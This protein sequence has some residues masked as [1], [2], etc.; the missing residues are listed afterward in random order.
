MDMELPTF[1][2]HPDPVGTGSVVAAQVVCESCGKARGYVYLGPVYGYE[3]LECVCPWCIADGS[4]HEK[5]GVSFM[6]EAGI[7]GEGEWEEV[8]EGVVEEV[9]Y[10]TPGFTGWQQEKWWTHC[11]DAAAFLGRVGGE[12]LRAMGSQAETA[13]R[14]SANLPVGM[15]WEHLRASLHKEGS[16][17]AY[18]FRCVRCGQY[19]GYYD[20]D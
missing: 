12:E 2:Y 9:A 6:D 14:Q 20:F 15:E 16:P 17:T 18:L 4:A 11:G 3:D 13:I 8:T 5:L 19:G 10:R 7:G 1:K